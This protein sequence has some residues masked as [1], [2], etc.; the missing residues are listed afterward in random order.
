[1][2]LDLMTKKQKWKYKG[3]P[4][5]APVSVHEGAVYVG[6]E[7]GMFHCVDAKTGVQRWIF[8]TGGEIASGANFTGDSIVF[9]CGDQHPYCLSR[10]GKPRWKFK[11]PGGPVMGSPAITGN[12]T[13]VAGCDSNLHVIDVKSGKPLA[14]I[15]LGGQ[16][17]A[18]AAVVGDTLYV[19]T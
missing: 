11:V 16:A 18:T 3:A 6:D 7:D 17:A 13:F 4:F 12:L 2:A 15:D 14:K 9:G 19:G 10:E 8:E 1:Y 5:K